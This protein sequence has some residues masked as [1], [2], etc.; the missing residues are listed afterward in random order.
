MKYRKLGR[1]GF[2][3]SEIAHGLWGMGDWSGSDD[4]T[5]GKI[6]SGI[7]ERLTLPQMALRYILSHPAVSTIIVGMRKPEH[8]KQNIA[9]SDAGSLDPHLLRK[10]KHHR[11][12]RKAESW[13]D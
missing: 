13:A 3:V 4:R 7:P 9:S 1:T 8:V 5:S 11:W 10:L 6:K 2:D 12:D